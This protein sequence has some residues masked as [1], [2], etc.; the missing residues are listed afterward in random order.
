MYIYIYTYIYI[1]GYL[2]THTYIETHIATAVLLR[3]L[4]VGLLLLGGRLHSLRCQTVALMR[5][6]SED[7]TVTSR[8]YFF[9][10]SL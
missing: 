3:G 4:L 2:H 9:V 5:I 8:T 10:G 7:I 6:A 1:Y